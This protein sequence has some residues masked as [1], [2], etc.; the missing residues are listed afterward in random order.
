MGHHKQR[1]RNNARL[2]EAERKEL[3]ELRE[4]N[5]K[6]RGK[7]IELSDEIGSLTKKL[8]REDE[9]G[10]GDRLLTEVRSLQALLAQRDQEIDGLRGRL[11]DAEAAAIPI[12]DQ[13]PPRPAGA[14]WPQPMPPAVPLIF[15]PPESK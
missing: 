3:A 8:L 5:G 1:D 4:E 14:P 10:R 13:V 12:G 9:V 2:N 6:L 11:T 15:L 7:I